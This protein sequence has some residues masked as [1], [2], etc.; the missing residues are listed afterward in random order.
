VRPRWLLE[1]AGLALG[2]ALAAR[3]PLASVQ[4]LLAAGARRVFARG[5]Q[6]QR[7]AMTNLRIAFPDAP[8]ESLRA[9]GAESYVHTAW[10]AYDLLRA[11]RWEAAQFVERFEFRGLEHLE[12]ALALGRGA[13]LLT[14]HLGN[15]DLAGRALSA[16]GFAVSAV[17]RMPR[18]PYL[19]QRLVR[20]R[21]RLGIELIDHRRALTAIM[22][23]LRHRRL[24]GILLDQYSRRTQGVFVPLF[25]KRCSTSAGLA[26]LALRSGAPIVHGYVV[27]DAPDHHQAV[28]EAPI[29]VPASGDRQADVTELT[30]RCNRAM[31]A[32]IRKHPEQWMWAH[33][34]FRHSPDLPADLY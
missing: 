1:A 19:Q 23:A 16:R 27:R 14:P 4:A 26:V 34:R 9:I 10:N 31:E 33:R 2:S 17:T 22:R 25:G 21:E 28:L 7:W 3:L 32:A 12:Q 5:S 24:V 20:Q 8:E 18:N 15:F 30:A 11:E 13:F 6:R 29:E